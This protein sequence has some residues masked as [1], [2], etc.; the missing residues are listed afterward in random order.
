MQNFLFRLMP[1]KFFESN[2]ITKKNMI[3]LVNS[4]KHLDFSS[5]LERI[6]RPVAIICGEKDR[7]NLRASK[8]LKE[9]LPQSRLYI[10]PN[11]G[12]EINKENPE[13]I[14]KILKQR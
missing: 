4:M 9:L 3:S 1:G 2:G 11:T 8:S 13:A 5:D 14:A 7:A 6:K 12:H 10:I